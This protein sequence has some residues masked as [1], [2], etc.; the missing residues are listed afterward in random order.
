MSGGARH[1]Q[2]HI[3]QWAPRRESW[4]SEDTTS[5]GA[6]RGTCATKKG[7]A[8]A[9]RGCS[10]MLEPRVCQ[11]WI[12]TSAD[13]ACLAG[14]G[15]CRHPSCDGPTGCWGSSQWD[16]AVSPRAAL[17]HSPARSY[18][19]VA[20]LVMVYPRAFAPT[21][22]APAPPSSRP[23]PLSSA[24]RHSPL[25]PDERGDRLGARCDRRDGLHRAI[26]RSY[27]WPGR[28]RHRERPGRA[29]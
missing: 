6:P 29:R 15:T 27:G 24:P 14:C 26:A 1:A 11:Q 19:A 13:F 2:A 18:A 16:C 20:S 9:R 8:D 22:P 23:P 10:V 28:Y 21:L 12:G 3:R 7:C 17:P 25:P 4:P 5:R